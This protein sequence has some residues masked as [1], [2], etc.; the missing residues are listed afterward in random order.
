M[1][2]Q[3][4]KSKSRRKFLNTS[5]KAG[6]AMSL[7]GLPVLS[8]GNVLPSEELGTGK[9]KTDSLNIL[10]LGGTSFLG[11]HQVAYALEQGHSVSIFTRGK[12]K[13]TIHKELFKEVEHLVGDRSNNLEALKGRK[14]DAVIDNSGRQVEWT[15]DTAELLRDN[16]ELYL[17]TS[18][19][20]VYYPYLGT[21]I[22][23]DTKPVL[24]VP[25]G[26]NDI[27]QMEYGYGVMKS[28]SEM[29]AKR[30]F[31]KDRTIVVR[32][33]YMMGPADQTD[34]FTYW[35]VRLSRGGN[36]MVPGKAEDPV[37]YI[38]VRDVAEWMIRLIENKTTGTFNAVGPASPTG[39]HA[40]VYGVHAAF[41]SKVSWEMIPDYKFLEKHNILDAVPWIMPVG[42]NFGSARA[43]N[44]HAIENGLTLTP[45]S[46]SVSD[47][48][49][50]WNSD[51]V[52][53]ERRLKMVS[54]ENGL[55]SIEKAII[56]EWKARKK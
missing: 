23:E 35:P 42:N 15:K 14:W 56:K 7:L 16:V 22:K 41:N 20:G 37:Q 50:W 18:S 17:Y 8:K 44:Q 36:I 43:N 40:F 53:E 51:A 6:A 45:L 27:Q 11:P 29:E 48:Y 24:K 47:I 13:P 28:N 46:K 34:R 10:I 21:D 3:S 32:P 38:D 39:M 9:K 4:K 52:T 2:K 19:T 1:Q 5:I 54:G 30:I 12:T 25:E 26:V 55:M 31:G 49:E 33:T